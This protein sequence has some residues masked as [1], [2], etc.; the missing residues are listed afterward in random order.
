M[1]DDRVPMHS[2]APFRSAER[3]KEGTPMNDK[4]SVIELLGNRKIC[5]CDSTITF[6]EQAAGVI[7][8]DLERY[9]MAQLLDEAGVPQITVGMPMLGESEKR[10]VRRIARLGLGTSIMSWNRADID[11][12]NASIESE[13]DAVTISIGTSDHQLRNVYN[14]DR[15]WVIDMIGSSVSYAVEHGLYV[16]C[17]A[18]D[19]PN[20]DLGFLIDFAKVAKAAGADR[21]GYCDSIGC[22][23]PFSCYDR[24]KLLNQIVGMPIEII[25]RNDLGLATAN[26]LAAVKAGAR[27][28]TTTSMGIGDRAGFAP[29]EEVD[30]SAKHILRLDSGVNAAKFTEI[31]EAVSLASGREIPAGKAIVG[32]KIF[33]QEAGVS[34]DGVVRD[35]NGQAFDPTEVG[36][37]RSVAIGKHSGRNTIIAE[38]SQMGMQIDKETADELLVLLRKACDQM[39]RGLSRK[40]LF[41]LYEDMMNGTDPFDANLN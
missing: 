10:A 3:V 7:F 4:N 16:S 41:L 28:V 26:S 19:A 20:T 1:I 9:R 24:I 11:D 34:A 27:F 17:V 14:Q 29:L 8:S 39:H 35:E 12:I 21:F 22:E 25:A 33:T 40:E 2:L 36:A 30:M 31:A 18:E 15:Q 38:L 32:T 5:I 37:V 6:G 23:D 13:V